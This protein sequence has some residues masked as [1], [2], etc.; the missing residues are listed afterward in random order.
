MSKFS[1]KFFENKNCEFYPC[2]NVD[3]INCLFCFC[4]LYNMD[5]CGGNYTR[6]KDNIKD[7]SKCTLPHSKGGYNY[8]INKINRR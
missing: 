8:I 4:P 5:D 1:Y 2:K 6:L 3:K 7:C